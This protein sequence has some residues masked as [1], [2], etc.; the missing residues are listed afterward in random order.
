MN[1]L[2]KV[3]TQKKE[4]KRERER[5]EV[6]FAHNDHNDPEFILP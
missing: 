5:D 6:K 3:E 2:A 4:E 1:V